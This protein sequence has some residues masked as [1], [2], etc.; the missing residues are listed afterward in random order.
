MKKIIYSGVFLVLVGCAGN[1]F[2]QTPPPPPSLPVIKLNTGS[3][4]IWQEYPASLEG[5][6]N[7]ELRSQVNGYLEKIYVEEGAYV[8]QGQPLFSINSNEYREYANNAGASIQVAKANI[9]KA[10]VE[11]D[12]IKPLVDNK[13]VADV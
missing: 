9:E 4:T 11:V 7:V 2:N 12:R 5:T 6:V 10:Q 13:V 1:Q 8:L 3:A